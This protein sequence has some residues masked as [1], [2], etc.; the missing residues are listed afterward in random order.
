MAAAI[1]TRALRA[2]L[3]ADRAR[4][5]TE[6]FAES[7][8]FVGTA[9]G[10]VAR[11]AGM[12]GIEVVADRTRG[13]A[14]VARAASTTRAVRH[15]AE[16][17]IRSHQP[18]PCA[19]GIGAQEPEELSP[20]RA[21]REHERSRAGDVHDWIVHR[22]AAANKPGSAGE[23][24]SPAVMSGETISNDAP[25]FRISPLVSFRLEATALDRQAPGEGCRWPWH[26]S[27]GA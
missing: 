19:E 16:R 1:R 20:R 24:S 12:G 3:K 17:D 5:A 18:Q 26:P 21:S 7:G 22:S 13:V 10:Q 8:A 9:A 15:R 11:T 27:R 23:T 2:T 6:P 25:R 4:P 14:G